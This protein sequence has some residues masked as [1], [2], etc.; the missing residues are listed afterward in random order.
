MDTTCSGDFTHPVG[1][2][3][4]TDHQTGQNREPSRWRFNFGYRFLLSARA[5]SF[6]PKLGQ[7]FEQR[8]VDVF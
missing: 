4:A 1:V 8:C 2:A 3:P 7:S 6:P 5:A